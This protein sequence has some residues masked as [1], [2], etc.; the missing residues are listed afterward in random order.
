MDRVILISPFKGR[1]QN[2]QVKYRRYLRQ[3]IRDSIRHHNEAPFA[4]HEMYTR[5]LS[6]SDPEERVIG[7]ALLMEWLPMAR[8]VVVYADHGISAGMK[9]ELDAAVRLCIP[10]HFR[11]IKRKKR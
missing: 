8:R 10:A 5:A 6:D 1:D 7:M 11:Y 9:A 4:G 3:A 2:E